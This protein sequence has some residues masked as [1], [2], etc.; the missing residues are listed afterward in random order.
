M[1]PV[2]FHTT[3]QHLHKFDMDEFFG[4]GIGWLFI[5]TMLLGRERY[6]EFFGVDS[7]DQ[8]L[9]NLIMLIEE[10]EK[11]KEKIHLNF[12]LKTT[13]EPRK[14]AASHPDF[15]LIDRLMGGK[16]L[17]GL[18]DT[19]FFVDDWCGAVKLPKY[20]RKR[21]LY[22]RFFRPCGIPVWRLMVYSN[23]KVG[24]CN[25][26]DFEA[27]SELVIGD[28]DKDSLKDLWNSPKHARLVNDWRSKNIIPAICKVCRNYDY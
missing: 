27:D 21:P 7:Y 26:S 1:K 19:S 6:K 15:K 9:K 2:W 20:L 11:R 8:V 25:C 22:P 5:S 14:V 12:S 23:G 4:S 10:N 17:Q 18:N 13:G 28:I 3:L 24:L 16:A